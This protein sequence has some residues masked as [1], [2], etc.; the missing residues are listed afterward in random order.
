MRMASTV[1]ASVAAL[2]TSVAM[3]AAEAPAGIQIALD[4][5]A[6]EA[7]LAA[8][9]GSPTMEATAAAKLPGNARLVE[10]QH[11]FDPEATEERLAR[12]LS[13]VAAG[14]RP[15]PDVFQLARVRERLDPTRVLLARM[16]ANPNGLAETLRQRIAKYTPAGLRIPVTV[17]VVAGGTSDGFSDGRVFC[18][19]I[20]Y[21]RDD[22]AGLRTMM[23]HELFH[24][25]YDAVERP[26]PPSDSRAARLISLLDDTRNEGI[27]SRVGDPL[28]VTDGKDW[29]EWF[30]GKFQKN[31]DRMDANFL[32]FDLIL[33]REA[34]DPD[35][36][37]EALT[38]IGFSGAFDSA[39]YFVGWEM[40]RVLEQERGASAIAES[41]AWSPVRFFEEYAAIARAHP[42]RVR[43]RFDAN[44]E[45]TLRELAGT[46]RS[47]DGG[48]GTSP[49]PARR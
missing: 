8:V 34:H 39:L 42:D 36:P 46:A 16:K 26:K 3:P 4:F 38:R 27:A 20:D 21:F 18:I 31:L 40:A 33:H 12:G 29:V 9:S 17:Y 10:H 41:L 7:T 13:D 14:K 1:A 5:Q 22:F 37:V 11:R 15:S 6:A 28:T 30:R 43:S 44:T 24:V 25:A 2:V 49:A 47:E 32:L 23:A 35:P 45:A 48:A 19:A